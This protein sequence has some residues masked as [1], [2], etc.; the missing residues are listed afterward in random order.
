MAYQN[1]RR[2]LEREI[3][4]KLSAVAD[5]KT[6]IIKSWVKDQLSDAQ[7]LIGDPAVKDL[8]SSSFRVVYPDLA[9]KTPEERRQRVKNLIGTLQETNPSYADVLIADNE[10]KVI[11]ASS[12]VLFQE[13]KSLR[14]IGLSKLEKTEAFSISPV[15]FSVPAQ[16]HVFMVVSPIHDDNANVVGYGILEIE[17]RPIHRLIEE[18]S[19]LG[20]TGEV[21]IIDRDRRMLT[22]SRFSE[23]STVL[24]SV[25]DNEA[26]RLGFQEKN[27][28]AVS[29][30]YRAVAVVAGAARL[31]CSGHG[32][33]GGRGAPPIARLRARRPWR[34]LVRCLLG[35]GGDP[36]PGQRNLHRG[37][38][39][40]P[41][42]HRPPGDPGLDGLE[43]WHADRRAR[44]H[45]RRGRPGDPAAR[46]DPISRS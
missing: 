21:I 44:R 18:R 45:P 29:R 10:G 26:L 41:V 33:A 25:P 8:L 36:C 1:S 13:G 9:A 4:N 34:L 39:R 12:K 6:H 15:F 2:S 37:C 20:N 23:E 43:P 24:K 7:N 30:D 3:L 11:A 32:H 35:G 27:G 19:G 16:Q 5:N 46:H 42:P 14:E 38:G 31:H 22:Q 17:L 28:V 40:Q